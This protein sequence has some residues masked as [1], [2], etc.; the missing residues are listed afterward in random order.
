MDTRKQLFLQLFESMQGLYK[1]L[2]R[3]PVSSITSVP[4]GQKAAL[5]SIGLHKALSGKQLALLLHV[6]PGAAA[7]H[8]EALVQA[9][10][11]SRETDPLTRRSVVVRLSQKGQELIKRL[12]KE[13]L[14][15]MQDVCNDI[16]DQ[17]LEIFVHVLQRMNQKISA[18]SEG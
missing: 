13:R 18:V 17:D 2:T 6:T 14:T 5:C 11:V 7:Q 12:E 8:I 10:L 3:R 16:T 4:F 1:G 9:G 15:Y